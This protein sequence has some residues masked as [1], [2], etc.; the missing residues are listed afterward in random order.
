MPVNPATADPPDS[1]EV[2]Q[3]LRAARARTGMTRKQLAR[4]SGTSERYLAHLEAGSGNPSL[5]VLNA[6]ADALDLPL[7]DLLPLGGER[8][9]AYARATAALRR[10]PAERLPAFH[11]WLGQAEGVGD[12]GRRIVL[13]GLRGAGKS[14]L[15]ELLAQRLEMPFVEMSKAVEAAYGGDIGLLIE[16]GGQGALRQYERDVWE[17]IIA[18]HPAAVIAAPGGIVADG[19]LYDRLLA[20]AHS[21]WLQAS[22]EDHMKRVMAQGDF[23][24]MA[25]NRGA[26]ADLKAILEARSAEYARADAALNTSARNLAATAD[27]LESI[28][29]RLLDPYM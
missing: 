20:S 11:D 27:S 18:S 28:S 16:L 13:V 14:A 29:A 1:A 24:P 22:P 21:I 4:I 8:S 7:V 9:V 26:M 5:E 10:V 12:K 17:D 25:S 23:R 6:L 2:G 19:P 3:N 15:G